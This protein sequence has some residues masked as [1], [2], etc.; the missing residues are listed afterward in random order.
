MS[1]GNEIRLEPPSNEP[2]NQ[3]IFVW[4]LYLLGGSDR[5]VNVEDATLK[6]FEIAPARFGWRTHPEIPDGVKGVKALSV[7]ENKSHKGLIH[8]TNKFERRLTPVGIRWVEK[9]RFFFEGKYTG[10]KVSAAQSSN[11]HER[12]RR[13]IRSS[14]T[15]ILFLDKPDSLEISDAAAALQCSPASPPAIWENRI[16]ELKRS[17]DLLGDKEVM[18][19]ALFIENRFLGKESSDD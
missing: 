1:A 12:R 18:S 4:A 6:C 15:W 19:F 16:N 9:Y 2:N 8:K 11:I 7:A 17:A 14:K 13:E 10:A 3:D 5:D